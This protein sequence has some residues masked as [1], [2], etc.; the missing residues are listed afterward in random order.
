MS[1]TQR[2]G[3]GLAIDDL[4]QLVVRPRSGGE[5]LYR[6]QRQAV[7]KLL[8]ARHVP[9]WLRDRLPLIYFDDEL[10]AIAGLPSWNVPAL[11]HRDY[12][13]RADALGWLC[14]FHISDRYG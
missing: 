14:E 6:G 11:V 7:K 8:A 4:S 2:A 9:V 5:T 12:E 13:A 3:E 10:V 1:I